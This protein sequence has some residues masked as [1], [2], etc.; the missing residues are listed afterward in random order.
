LD[1]AGGEL[2]WTLYWTDQNRWLGY[3]V[4]LQ[5]EGDSAKGSK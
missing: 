3:N 4:N 1:Q 5:I 2:S